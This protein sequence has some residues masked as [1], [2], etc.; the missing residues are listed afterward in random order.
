MK[1]SLLYGT[2]IAL[3]GWIIIWGIVFG[4]DPVPIKTNENVRVAFDATCKVISGKAEATGVL[5]NT[6]YVIT[7]AHMVDRNNNGKIDKNERDITLEFYSQQVKMRADIIWV[8]KIRRYD[9][10]ILKPSWPVKSNVY[11]ERKNPQY[12]DRIFTIGMTKGEGPLITEGFQSWNTQVYTSRASIFVHDGNSGGGIFNEHQNLVGIVSQSAQFRQMAD[13][14]VRIP[15]ADGGGTIVSGQARVWSHLA[16]WCEYVDIEVIRTVL[17]QK[18]FLFLIEEQSQ[19]THFN[20][21]YFQMAFHIM[22]V[23]IC[24]IWFRRQLLS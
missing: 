14:R 3:A 1:K 8:G 23:L 9:F 4:L 22:G 12:G 19:P 21:A 15:S 10:A 17:Q 6:G 16:A 24:V 20:W 5:L 7:A 2:L 13:V 11:V 18:G